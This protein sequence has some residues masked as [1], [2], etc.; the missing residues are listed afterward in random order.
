MAL[1]LVVCSDAGEN[2]TFDVRRSL[3][4]TFCD[5]YLQ[6]LSFARPAFCW[7]AFL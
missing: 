4:N 7:T 2:C 1:A 6:S 3:Q 5:K